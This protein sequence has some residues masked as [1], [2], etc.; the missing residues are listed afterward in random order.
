MS[1]S[2]SG[3]SISWSS[4]SSARA[5]AAVATSPLRLR[6]RMRCRSSS[7]SE[8]DMDTVV[9]CSAPVRGS[10]ADTFTMP[11]ALISKRTSICVSLRGPGV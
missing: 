6:L 10:R 2:T 4:A 9:A 11:S 5:A 3:R 7:E 1:L 8:L